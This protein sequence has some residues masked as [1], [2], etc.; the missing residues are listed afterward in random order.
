MLEEQQIQEFVHRAFMDKALRSELARQPAEVIGCGDYSSRV[1]AILL[2]LVPC[3]V[4]E[5]PLDM[6]AEWWHA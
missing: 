2:R 5:Q 3:L 6:H 4:F 1:M